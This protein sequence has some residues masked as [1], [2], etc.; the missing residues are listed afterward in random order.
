[1]AE[2]LDL[3]SPDDI[4][5]SASA[6]NPDKLLWLNAHYIKNSPN[7]RLADLLHADH[8]I[9]VH[10]HDGKE[11]LLDVTKEKA[12]LLAELAADV[13]KVVEDPAEYNEKDKGKVIDD[14]RIAILK[15]F[16]AALLAA[17]TPMHL[18]TDY[19]DFIK[20][21]LET[22]GAKMPQLGQPLRLAL[23]G[24]AKG[25]GMGEALAVLG[26]KTVAG[27]IDALLAHLEG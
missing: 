2:M 23:F 11:I 19:D 17:E 14:Q 24:E 6:Y 12:K 18:P 16:K 9:S 4:N 8:G 25:M 5:K 20:A 22:E 7:D 3:F 21:F 15:A 26:K 13:K 27:R 10:D 1:M